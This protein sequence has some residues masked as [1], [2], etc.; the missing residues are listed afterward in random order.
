MSEEPESEPAATPK[1][2]G[3][4]KKILIIGLPLLILLGGGGGAAYVMGMVPPGASTGAA[5]CLPRC[6]R[7]ICSSSSTASACGWTSP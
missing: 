1:A 5:R 6:V 2:G 4:W 7:R 3:G